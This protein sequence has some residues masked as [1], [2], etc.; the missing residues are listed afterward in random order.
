LTKMA[1]NHGTLSL[2][3]I[4]KNEDQYL[5]DCLE[6]VREVV[7]QIIIVDTG[8]TDDTVKIAKQF[9]AEVHYFKWCDDFSAARN[10]SIKYAT[11][12]WILWMDADERLL[13][14]S[15]PALKSVLKFENRPVIYEVTIKNIRKD[16]ET[17]ALSSA[18]RLFTNHKGLFFTGRIH[19]QISPSAAQLKGDERRSGILLYHLGY[20]FEGEEAEKKNRRN[21][22]LLQRMVKESPNSAYAHYTLA[23]HYVLTGDPRKALNHYR[24]AFN[25]KQFDPAMNVSLL[26]TWAEALVKLN[27]LEEARSKAQKSIRTKPLQAGGYYLLYKISSAENK[28]EEAAAWLEEL[29]VK[30]RDLKRKEKTISTDVVIEEEKILFTLGGVFRRLGRFEDALTCLTKVYRKK[31][32]NIPLLEQLTEIC[33]QIGLLGDAEKYISK[34]V[35][36]TNGDLKYVEMLGMVAIKQKN[37]QKAIA[38]YEKIHAN[39]PGNTAVLKRLAGLF[40]KIGA[41]EKAEKLLSTLET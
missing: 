10:E 17:Y 32:R 35:N 13:P 39:M 19:E 27:R 23:Q 30:T 38:A 26:N 40:G 37:Y 14:E 1:K 7:D 34:L 4:V 24:T 33:I 3:M 22:N 16:G 36:F 9:G 2:C 5:R 11:S 18:H 20:S 29:L 6:S 28:D 31:P 21:R 12:D 41:I 25:L 15:I 8:S